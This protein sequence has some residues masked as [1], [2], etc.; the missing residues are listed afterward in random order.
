[1]DRLASIDQFRALGE[2]IRVDRAVD[3]PT[4]II[5]AGT[6]GQ[7]SGANDLI[8]IT[9][10]TMLEHGLA[11]SL[12]V[13]I[14]G[15]HGYCQMEPSML[16]E[17]SR[18]FYPRVGIE[19]V[20]RIVDAA[21][22]GEVVE[23]LLFVDPASG[24]RIE[25]QDEIPFFANQRRTLL[26]RNERLDPIRV[27]QAINAGGYRAFVRLL[28]SGSPDDVIEA[29]KT[30]GLRGRGGA[31]FPTWRK[32]Q[33][34]ADAPAG[35]GKF[36]ICNADEGDPGAYMDR[37]LLEGN[38]H[39]II[40]GM[41]IGAF[42]TGATEGVVYVRAEYPLAIK[43][44]TI[45]LRQARELGLLGED[46]LGIGLGFD[47]DLV[48][49]AGAFV[50]GEETALIASVEGR[51]GEPR[52]RPPF[53]VQRGIDG[54]PTAINNVETWANVVV[55]V[56]DGP[57]AFADVCTEDNC[58]T[59]IFS[60]VGKVANTGL[61]EVP[62]GTKIAD[63]VYGIGGGSASG[64]P[65]KAVQ[66]GGPSGGCIPAERFDLPIDYDSLVEAGSIMGSGGMIVMDADTCMV[67]VA[68]YFLGFLRDESCGKCFTCRKG[69]QRLH[70]ILEDITEGRGTLE[71]LDLLEELALVVRDTSMC[72]LGQS[73]ANPVLTTLRY[74]RH[75]YERHVVDKRCDAFV[76]GRLVGAPCQSACPVGTEAWKYVA[77]VARGEIDEAY[78]VIRRA[79]P[80]PSVCARACDHP[81]ESRCR[82]ATSGGSAVAIRALKRFVTDRVDPLSYVPER[83]AW[84]GAGEPPRIAVVG[85]GPAG[86][87][88][89]HELSLAGCRVSLLEAESEPGG[90][91]Y[92]AIPSY[93]LPGEVVRREIEA[94]LDDTIE[95]HCG[96]S[97][98]RDVTVDGLLAD[99]FSAVLLAMGAHKS[100][101]LEL[102]GEDAPGVL[103][104]IDFLKA[105]NLR[106]EQLARGRVGVIGGG[107]SAIDAAR[108]AVR[109]R[110]VDGVTIFY[111]R[112]RTE[113]P[114]FA[115]E[116]EAALEEGIA[117]ET[118]VTPVRIGTTNGVFSHLE[119]VRNTLGEP[120][121]SGRRRPVAVPGSEFTLEL[122]TLIVAISE[123]SGVDALGPARSGGIETTPANTVRVD[124]DTLRT[125]RP[126]VF[127]AGDVVTGPNTIIEA[128]AAGRRAAEMI[129]HFVRGEPLEHHNGGCLPTGYV[130]PVELGEG[131][132]SEERVETPRASVAWRKRNFAEVEVTLSPEEAR[133]E[134]ARCLRCDLEFT[135]PAERDEALVGG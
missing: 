9:K 40:E 24:R 68:K 80:F 67:D 85:A 26:A 121:A 77:H 78:R 82:A 117:I 60:L 89:A 114:A 69:T 57:E 79:N 42:A 38:P 41:L 99:G 111:R 93:R 96:V 33:M 63:I 128:V 10:R 7:A 115:E 73:A 58:G 133:A 52:Q 83:R 5:P 107:N 21:A 3:R 102:E 76:C 30:A 47:I 72:G 22:R 129:L 92:C 109:Q 103:P 20:P 134:A 8:R 70:E 120:D 36:L 43:H 100:R 126:E 130:A 105:F 13:R 61:V 87:T 113:M 23:D 66:T 53:P 122:D 118:L 25:R 132:L 15:C 28:E 56:G 65:I 18:T 71:Q 17:P 2:R 11:E 131:G 88:A 6:C 123:D 27:Y 32:W 110:D 54:R 16:V 116:I 51:M 44:L 95:V 1:M 46:I 29:L 112:T 39:S 127:A 50:C 97:V 35:G 135:R 124:A 64:K 108:T 19:D 86:L 62:M 104:S 119:C 84:D 75:E 4:L 98:G 37:S 125:S 101:P 90:M 59:K 94:L 31:G 74:F 14:T 55:I 106:G 49:G 81:C 34:L 48:R 91:L 12:R 45:A